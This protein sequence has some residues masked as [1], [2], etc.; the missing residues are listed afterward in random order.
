MHEQKLILTAILSSHRRIGGTTSA[1]VWFRDRYPP[2]TSLAVTLS[3]LIM[4]IFLENQS[5]TNWRPITL[6]LFTTILCSFLPTQ[7]QSVLP[8]EETRLPMLYKKAWQN[9]RSEAW[10]WSMS[11]TQDLSVPCSLFQYLGS[12]YHPVT[13]PFCSSKN[14][15]I[16]LC[17]DS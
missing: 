9:P 17:F 14:A 13:F 10:T 1:V 8:V 15:R 2:S 4:K 11:Q 12:F 6:H 5:K 16:T 3:V 7:R